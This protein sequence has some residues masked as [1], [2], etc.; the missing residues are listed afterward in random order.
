MKLHIKPNAVCIKISKAESTRTTG[1]NWNMATE[2]LIE[3][4][5]SQ[6]QWAAVV[7][8]HSGMGTPVTLCGYASD[9]R[10]V[11]CPEIE[12][13]QNETDLFK[14][15]SAATLKQI[16]DLKQQ[17]DGFV[18]NSSIKKTDIKEATHQLRCIYD[19]LASNVGFV[20]E[21]FDKH[22]ENKVTSAK[23]DVEAHAYNFIQQ[24]GIGAIQDQQLKIEKD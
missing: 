18:A 21:Q 9:E 13:P 6:V 20:A 10:W 8:S 11:R 4:R 22:V 7:A 3:I 15:E 5:M 23:L 16:N 1:C 24:M 14:D 19:N 17:L 2:P 12:L